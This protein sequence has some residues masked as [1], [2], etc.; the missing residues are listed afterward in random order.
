MLSD[1]SLLRVVYL[2]LSLLVATIFL[3]SVTIL[4][5]LARWPKRSEA[6]LVVDLETKFRL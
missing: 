6:Y 1:L 3:F 4:F 5:P 2:K